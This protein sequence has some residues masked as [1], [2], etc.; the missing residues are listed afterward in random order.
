VAGVKSD[1][2][3]PAE[4]PQSVTA[5]TRRSFFA[6]DNP[7]IPVTFIGEGTLRVLV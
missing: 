7:V 6:N 2:S 1:R 5:I 3:G 4:R